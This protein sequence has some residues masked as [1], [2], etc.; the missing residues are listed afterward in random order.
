MYIT[1]F[2][3]I[4]FFLAINFDSTAFLL[5]QVVSCSELGWSISLVINGQ[6]KPD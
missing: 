3:L 1:N 5:G 2:Q 4:V 6:L